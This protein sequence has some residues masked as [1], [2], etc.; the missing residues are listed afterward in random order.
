MIKVIRV[1]ANVVINPEIG[2]AVNEKYGTLLLDEFLKVLISNPFKKNEELV[3]SILSTLNNLSY[4]Y[5][6]EVELDV[7][8]IKQIEIIEGITEYSKSKNKECVIEAMRIMGNLSRSKITR[9]FITESEVFKILINVLSKVDLTLLKTTI[10]V[11]VN[12]MADNKSRNLFKNSGGIGKLITILNSFA[13]NDW[14]LA[15]LVC[16]VIWNYCIDTID[17]YEL[18]PDSEIQQLLE[19]LAELL[20][21]FQQYFSSKTLY[22]YSCISDDEKLFGITEDSDEDVYVTQDYLIWEEFAGVATNILEKI[23]YFLET[24][25]QIHINNDHNLPQKRD[26]S[27]NLTLAAWQIYIPKIFIYIPT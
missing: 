6:S 17:L 16:Q 12:L 3:M 15:M 7:F 18:I 5:T 4:Y 26:S 10:G 27:T 14:I 22:Y 11:F 21:K 19:V 25:D 13:Q 24:F 2:K 23:E 9:D 8:H 20:G 1:I